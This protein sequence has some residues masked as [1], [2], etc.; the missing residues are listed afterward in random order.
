MKR[1]IV[2]WT[3]IALLL[4]GARWAPSGEEASPQAVI[5]KAIEA[6][7]GAAKLERNKAATWTEK[8]TYYGMGDGLPYT[9]SYAVQWPDRFRMEIHGVFTMVINGDQGWMKSDK[10]TEEM[11]KDVV[12]ARARDHKAGW[13][14]TLIPLKNKA[15]KLSSLPEAKVGDQPVR[16]VVVRRKDYPDVKLF[17]DKKTGLLLRS[18]Y[19]SQ[20]PEL[21][22]KEVAMESTFGDYREIEGA[23]VPCHI[24]MKRAGKRFVEADIHDYKAAG[25][26]DAKVF[27]RP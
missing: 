17:F 25:K 24:V 21:K 7:G 5:T 27:S 18:E 4:A 19:K 2:C 6:M 3:A 26:L 13:V 8:G 16:G 22:L 12:A 9:G 15:F 20:V 14:T 11:A 10:G 23:K 1:I